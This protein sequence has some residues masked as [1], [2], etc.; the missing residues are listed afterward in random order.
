[1]RH[2]L[3]SAV[4][5]LGLSVAVSAQESPPTLYTQGLEL[6]TLEGEAFDLSKLQGKVVLFVNVASECGLT[7]QYEKLQALHEKYEDRGLVLVGV[8]ANDF[9]AQEPGTAQ[10]IREFCTSKYQVTFPLLEKVTVV[11]EQKAPLYRFL[12]TSNEAKKGEVKWN[13]TKF[14]VDKQGKVIDR[15]EPRVDP[16]DPKVIA[17]I[18]AA[19]GA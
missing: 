3:A 15:F 2:L 19:L 18:E 10:Q 11:G 1:M 13:F 9:G 5:V 12:T 7:P 8:P 14:L 4:T 16:Q 17:A 6:K